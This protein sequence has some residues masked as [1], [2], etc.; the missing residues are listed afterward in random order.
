[1]GYKILGYAVWQGA[2]WYFRRQIPGGGRRLAI[3]GGVGGL[4]VVAG[5]VALAAQRRANGS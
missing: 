2:K 5:A 4:L 3:A 1:M